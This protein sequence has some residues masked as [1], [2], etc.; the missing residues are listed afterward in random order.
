MLVDYEYKNGNL[1]CSY[2]NESGNI[3]LKYFPFQSPKKFII[4]NESDPDKHGKYVTW[5]G[6]SVKEVYTK[7]PN[8][9]SIYNYLDDLPE[10]DKKLLFD[11]N[12]PNIWFIDIENEILNEKPKPHLANSRVLSISIVNKDKALV[13]GL[14]DLS[15]KDQTSIQNDINEKYGKL[16]NKQWEFKYIKYNNEFDLLYNFFNK[17]VPN[18]AVITGWNVKHYDWVFLVNRARNIG[19]D[20]CVSSITG[21]LTKERP[22][23]LNNYFEAPA[24]KVII[25]YMEIFDKWDT[26]IKVKESNALDFVSEKVLGIK[27]VNYEGNLKILYETD[28][29][30]FIYYN[31]ID[32]I[33]VQLIHEKTKLSNI[34]YSIAVLSKITINSAL[35]TLAITEGFLR[36]DLK[37]LKNIVLVKN[38]LAD[39]EGGGVKGGWVKEP[40]RGMAEWTV[41]FDFSSLYPTTMRQFNI[42]ADSYK[43]QKVKDKNYALFNGY[44][45]VVEPNDIITKNGSVFRREEGVV[46]KK[47]SD[48]FK[49]RK[50][51]KNMMM[52]KHIE[53]ENLK[54]EYE[55][56]EKQIME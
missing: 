19:I 42:S 55:E 15:K 44:Q 38:D 29:K 10:D 21:K 20:P 56:L 4:T 13:I 24:H 23:D 7:W 50:R 9:Y 35:S 14:D 39:N 11:Y 37:N 27:K 25:D 3:K 49:D 45:I 8:K 46:T 28:F 32:S 40:V 54:K 34:L 16:F 41:C 1:I 51:Y 18:M 30:K 12:E 43:G 31:V 22:K 5:D 6:K 52:A 47:I 36:T 26:S 17:I 53:L 2:I 33:L 48:I